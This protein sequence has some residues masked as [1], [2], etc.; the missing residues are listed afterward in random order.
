MA[1]AYRVGPDASIALRLD[2]AGY[3]PQSHRLALRVA[4]HAY[5]IDV[6]GFNA[7]GWLRVASPSFSF[8]RAVLAHRDAVVEV[9]LTDLGHQQALATE[10][11]VFHQSFFA[12]LVDF[13]AMPMPGFSVAPYA[14][15]ARLAVFTHAFNDA[16]M[17]RL[18]E[19]HYTGFGPDVGLYVLDHGSLP[20]AADAVSSR[21]HCVP[22]P[23]GEVDNA[24]LAQ[25]CNHFQRMLLTQYRWVVHVDADELL[26]P[27]D[28]IA[29]WRARL[30]ADAGPPRIVEPAHGVDL[31]VHPDLEAPLDPHRPI[32]LQRR[33]LVRNG[34]YRKPVL[35]S[36]PTTWGP[37]FHYAIETHD[38][39][40]DPQLWLVHLAHADVDLDVA[41]NRQWLAA[42]SS[43]TDAV[44]VDH[45]HRRVD[46]EGVKADCR[47]RV[48]SDDVVSMPDWMRGAL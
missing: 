7:E 28:G 36:R 2:R 22:L 37:G 33:F 5:R 20:P 9:V 18:W 34:D 21:V 8:D 46:V 4:G 47:R 13:A 19:R 32:T 39:T 31:V 12:P 42:R 40:V 16:A 23:R 10:P 6:D 48:H 15:P 24:N 43:V 25:F 26:V 14:K 11:L 35:A 17:L 30:D 29:A 27:E 45:S 1:I 44:R 38:V 41:R 3:D